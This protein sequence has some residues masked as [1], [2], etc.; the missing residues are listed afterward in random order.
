MSAHPHDHPHGH[1]IEVPRQALIAAGLLIGLTIA[2][3]AAFRIAGLE[4]SARIPAAEPPVQS[5]EL[6]FEDGADGSVLVY[7]AVPDGPDRVIHVVHSGEGG[8]IRGIL[9]SLARARTAS[10][11]GPEHP[12]ILRQQPSGTLLLEDPQTR[13]RID[14][15]A[16]GPTN[17][18][19]FRVLLV[20]HESPS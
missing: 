3:V 12:F 20:D 11:I 4:P 14:L 17:I 8:F 18:E 10:G 13:Q 2:A 16:F 1:S 6:R 15:Q 19:A 5:R 9:R 7:A